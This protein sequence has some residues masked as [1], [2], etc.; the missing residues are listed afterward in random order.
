MATS[1][2][3]LGMGLLWTGDNDD[4]A[5][6]DHADDDDDLYFSLLPGRSLFRLLLLALMWAV[7]PF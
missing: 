5:D 6:D 3:H 4:D 7:S 2:G 1:S